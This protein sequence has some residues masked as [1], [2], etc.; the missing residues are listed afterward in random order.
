MLFEQRFITT[1]VIEKSRHKLLFFCESDRI[2]FFLHDCFLARLLSGLIP[3]YSSHQD[4]R[5]NIFLRQ[6]WNDPRLKLP[7]DWRG[8]DTLTV[9][10]TMFKCLWKPD[11]FFANE[12]NANFHDVTQEN[13]LLFIFRD[14][15]V[16]V[17]MRYFIDKF[18]LFLTLVNS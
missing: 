12:K 16:L 13:I 8:S 5:V 7:N 6:K 3:T 9:D 15:D 1:F 10:P 2:E 11:L 14:G 17:S 4:Y 18:I